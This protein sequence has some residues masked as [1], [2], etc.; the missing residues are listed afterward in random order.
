MDDE[1][2]DR[3]LLA[4]MAAGPAEAAREGLRLLYERHGGPVLAFLE[5]LVDA[6]TAED[7]LQETFLAAHRAA[8]GFQRGSARPWLLTIAARRARD[9]L[10]RRG[11]RRERGPEALAGVRAGELEAGP[12]PALEAALASLGARDRAVLELR[13]TQGLSHPQ[14]A[15]TLG[16]SLRTA[17][18]WCARALERLRERLEEGR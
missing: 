10:R 3:E 9:V 16:V 12:D 13:F 5:T 15:C 11:R 2:P 1:P 6:A 17:K 4:R 8:A 18:D 14:V 7:L